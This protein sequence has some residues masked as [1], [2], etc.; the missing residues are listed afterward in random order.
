MAT[1]GTSTVADCLAPPGVPAMT[2]R[3]INSTTDHYYLL[4]RTATNTLS[5]FRS[6]DKGASWAAWTS[7]THTGLQEWSSPIYESAGYLHLAYRVSAGNTD[8]IWYRR[9]NLSNVTWSAGLQCSGSP[10]NGGV[11]GS[12]FQGVD[13]AVVRNP[14]TSYAIIVG[15]AYQDAAGTG[16]QHGVYLHGVSIEK[17]AGKIYLNNGIITGT[18]AWF[19]AGTPGRSG[20][21]VE[22]EHNGDG[23]TSSV[24]NVWVC[25]GR[26]ELRMVKVGWVNSKVGWQGPASPVVM[27]ST[28]PSSQDYTAGRWDG[29]QWLMAVPS[30]DDITMVRVYQ[31]NKANTT[32]ATFTSPAHPAGVVRNVALTYD[33][34]TKNFRLFAVGTSSALLYYIDYTRATATWGAWATVSATAVTG[35]TEWSVRRGGNSG[36]A[37]FDVVTT[38][39]TVTPWTVS[40][41]AMTNPTPPSVATWDTT[42]SPYV[43]G[44]PAD[45]GSNLALAWT[46]TD[47][48]PGQT[49][50]SYA[51]SRQIGAGTLQYWNAT[52]STWGASEVQNTSSTPAVTLPAGWGADADA[53][54]AYRVKV[55]DSA[56]T[57]AA[58]YSTAL[59]LTPSVLVNPAVTAPTAAQVLG[60]DTVTVQWTV[61]EQSGARIRLTNAG[62]EVVYDSGPMMGYTDT[63]FTVPLRLPNASAWSVTLNTYNNERLQSTGQ[64]R[65][66]TVNFSPAPAVVS[67]LLPVTAAGVIRVTPSVLAPVGVQPAIVTQDLYRRR[68]TALN[69]LTNS[70]FAGSVNGWFGQ[71]GAL[72][73]STTQARSGPGSARLV[74]TGGFADAQVINSIQPSISDIIARGRA[75]TVSG[76]IRCDTANKPIRVQVNWL[77]AGGGFL[78]QEGATVATAIAGAWLYVEYTADPSTTPAAVKAAAVIGLTNTPAAGDAFYVDDVE[79]REANTDPGVRVLALAEPGAVYDDWG[80]ASGVDYEY[81]WITAASNGTASAGPWIG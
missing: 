47:T 54:H 22:V 31:R 45:V 55:W 56:N 40:H 53:A 1:V 38:A 21:S 77:D 16:A 63:E 41:T 48:D 5:V 2:R 20:I 19:S 50:G 3:Y 69:L 65:A 76:W 61:A 32:S 15:A 9:L 79:L 33:N 23:Q 34:T 13:L 60:I 7:F 10:A 37:R 24:P 78:A 11:A 72:T 39:G 36:N 6:T 44:G 25:W 66:F 28:L 42:G 74:P 64:T 30:P 81:R 58:G 12:R 26:A 51:L 17:N 29:T 18:R 14:D 4:V 35:A 59:L 71:N 62:G 67:T 80:A 49:Q 8:T 68:R 57:P 46:F 75:V 27:R 70:S 52:S 73:Y 43:N